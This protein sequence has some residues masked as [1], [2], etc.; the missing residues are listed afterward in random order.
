MLSGGHCGVTFSLMVSRHF[1]GRKNSER[2][3]HY[4]G[5][6]RQEASLIGVDL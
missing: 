1:R 4:P 6:H 5:Y 2:A 3:S